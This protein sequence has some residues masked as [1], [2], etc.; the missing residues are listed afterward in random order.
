MASLAEES[1]QPYNKHIATLS[2][3][4][5]QDIRKIRNIAIESKLHTT[6]THYVPLEMCGL[7]Y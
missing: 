2:I 4:V 5:L 7:D 3:W 1:L 6:G